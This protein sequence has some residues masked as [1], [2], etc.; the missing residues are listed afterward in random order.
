MA[1]KSITVLIVDDAA[2]TRENI[3]RLLSLSVG[4]T[5]VGEAEDGD[6]AIRKTEE[7][8][9]N[10]VLMDINMPG[11]DGISAT[12]QI[13]AAHPGTVVIVISVQG[14]MEYLRKSMIAGA[15]DYLVKPFGADEL[16]DCIQKTWERELQRR[17]VQIT[18]H[19]AARFTKASGKVIAVYS[20]KGGVGKTTMAVNLAALL[21]S[22][23]RVS[24]CLLDL[25]LQFGD[26]SVLLSLIP[27]R[28]ISDLVNEQTLDK[29]TLLS[30]MLNH[31]CGLK[32]LPAPLRPEYAE[33]V[34]AEHV[35]KVVALCREIFD[36]VVI[37]MP[38]SFHETVLT[39]LDLT[40]RIV[41][42]GAMDMPTLKN[43]K[44]GLEV[45]SRLGYAQDKVYLMVNRASYE[46]GIKFKDLEPAMGRPVDY[47]LPAEDSAVMTA[48]NRGIPFVLDPANLKLIKRISELADALSGDSKPAAEA[49]GGFFRWRK[50]AAK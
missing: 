38:A 33:Y 29:E 18:Q 15:K 49:S 27:R 3:R 41:M 47:Y 35:G 23:R 50:G 44:L 40:D 19:P 9:P 48:A 28:T 12:E 30:Y 26:A 45:M 31:P 36:Y 42:V 17:V 5:V 6:A 32:V 14:E 39:T 20:T 7:L 34:T 16:V 10:V 11:L 43:V 8:Q 21:A 22:E 13:C 1:D 25:D 46:Y 37:D 4:F 24:T 2:D